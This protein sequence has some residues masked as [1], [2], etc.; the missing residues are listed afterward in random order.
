MIPQEAK[1]K[2]VSLKYVKELVSENTG[3][4]FICDVLKL[5]DG[6]VLV[7]SEEIVALYQDLE[8]WENS[9]HESISGIIY[10]AAAFMPGTA[11]T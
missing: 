9:D 6:T 1:M 2:A 3:G 5:D 11:P 10:R 8:A 7:I 4:G